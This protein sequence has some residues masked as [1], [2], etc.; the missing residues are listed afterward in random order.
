MTVTTISTIQTQA[1]NDALEAAAR[2]LTDTAKDHDQMAA[3]LNGQLSYL[4]ETGSVRVRMREYQDKA[5]L[6]RGQAMHVLK[7]K[8]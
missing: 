6:L 4:R 1:Y 2:L 8:K 7:L 5:Q 3:Q